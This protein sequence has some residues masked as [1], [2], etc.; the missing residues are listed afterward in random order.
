MT[1]GLTDREA[2]IWAAWYAQ[3]RAHGSGQ[4]EASASAYDEVVSLRGYGPSPDRPSD[5]MLRSM[6]GGGEGGDLQTDADGGKQPDI[7][8]KG[9]NSKWE[10]TCPH[11]GDDFEISAVPAYDGTGKPEREG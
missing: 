8:A 7:A 4:V 3:A 10:T 11:C 1:Q 5:S 6:L 2:M 9:V